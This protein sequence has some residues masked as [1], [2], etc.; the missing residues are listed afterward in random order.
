MHLVASAEESVP[1]K[2]YLRIEGK[3]MFPQQLNPH[4]ENAL[5]YKQHVSF[6][7]H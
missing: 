1:R 3:Q 6:S 2:V 7:M 4:Y 5:R